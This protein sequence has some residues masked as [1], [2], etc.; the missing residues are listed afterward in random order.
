MTLTLFQG[1]DIDGE[2]LNRR[3]LMLLRAVCDGFRDPQAVGFRLVGGLTDEQR[4][5]RGFQHPADLQNCV[6]GHAHVPKFD[7]RIEPQ[8][9]VNHFSSVNKPIVFS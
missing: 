2:Q 8:R 6:N 4:V 7:A 1:F 3:L 9:A 5:R